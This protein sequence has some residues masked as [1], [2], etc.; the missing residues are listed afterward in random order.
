MSKEETGGHNKTWGSD[1]SALHRVSTP[2]L[3]RD[4]GTPDQAV[5]GRFRGSRMAPEGGLVVPGTVGLGGLQAVMEG[6][7]SGD[8]GTGYLSASPTATFYY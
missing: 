4:S 2:T 5:S 7:Y 1:M 3:A 6:A 8:A